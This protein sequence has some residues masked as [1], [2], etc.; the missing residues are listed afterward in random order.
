LR[1]R[2]DSS[3]GWWTGLGVNLVLSLL[4]LLVAPLTQV[5]HRDWAI[6]VGSYF[7]TFLLADS[8]TTNAL[9]VDAGRVSRQL[10]AGTPLRRILLAKNL[11]LMLVVGLPTL[12]ATGLITLQSEPLARL[13]L[14]MPAVLGPVLVWLGLGN[15][16]SV[17][18]PVSAL[19]LRQRWQQRRD[20]R[21]TGRWLSVVALP[22]AL[23]LVVDPLTQ[24]PT[25]VFRVVGTAG[26]VAVPAAVLLACG[27]LTYAALTAAA[28]GA[29]SW[30]PRTSRFDA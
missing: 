28:L 4:Y 30:S 29:A 15:L 25:L 26:S 10:D 3:W 21:S 7:A 16:A 20:L 13:A 5:A 19:P 27:L 8:T 12:A 17:L 9:G 2:A 1:V 23:C 14:T 6:L 11:T 22:Y 18:L 24:L